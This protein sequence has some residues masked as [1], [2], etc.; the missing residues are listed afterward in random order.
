MQHVYAL[1]RR[2]LS[3][4]HIFYANG[5]SVYKDFCNQDGIISAY[6]AISWRKDLQSNGKLHA[7][8]KILFEGISKGISK[9]VL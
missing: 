3:A 7:T 9:N 6:T 1:N 4:Y 5:K 2:I 8:H